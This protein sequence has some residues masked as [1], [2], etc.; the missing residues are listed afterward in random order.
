MGAVL[1]MLALCVCAPVL[2]SLHAQVTLP[3]VNRFHAVTGTITDTLGYPLGNADVSIPKLGKRTRTKSDGT[4]RFDSIAPGSYTIAARSIGYIAPAKSVTVRAQD[5]DITI[6]M[7]RFATVL[8]SVVSSA[9]QTGLSGIIGDTTY[10]ALENVKISV[11]GS[12]K[13]ALTDSAG[14]FYIDL[15]EGQYM[16]RVE[17]DGFARQLVGVS[18]PKDEGRKIAAWMVP[19]SGPANVM[20]GVALFD[21][22]QRLMR[23][24]PASAKFFTR[25][26]LEEKGILDLAGLARRWAAGQI[27]GECRIAMGGSPAPIPLST[28]LTSDIEFVE[29]YLPT[30]TAGGPPRGVTSLNGANSQ[31]QASTSVRPPTQSDC[32]NLAMTVWLRN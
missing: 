27:N 18:I 11:M 12:G 20:Q 10:R 7:I 1:I 29:L 21:L 32:G 25:L 16:L 8:P 19:Q 3:T 2:Q 6:E 30:G 5:V 4:F 28:V 31:I 22:N 13:S 23:V 15:S 9:K 17:R 24:S 26:D 14:A